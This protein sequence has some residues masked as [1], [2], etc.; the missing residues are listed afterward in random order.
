[1]RDLQ[2]YQLHGVRVVELDRSGAQLRN[3]RDAVDVIA[4]A[5][6]HRPELIAIPIE[7]LGDEFFR[8][9]TRIAGEI[10]QKFLMYHFRVAILGDISKYLND[11]SALRD[12]VYECNAGSQVWFVTD[13]EELSRKLQTGSKAG[14]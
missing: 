11:S 3:D 1:M 4:F 2:T 5:S 9:K 14:L 10:I 6:G 12:F 8:L 7:R 13:I